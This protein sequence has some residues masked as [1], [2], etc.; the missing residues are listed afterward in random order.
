MV[1]WRIGQL[2]KLIG[3]HPEVVRRYEK[4]GVIPP[5]Q[6]DPHNGW[7]VWPDEEVLRIQ[8]QFQPVKPKQEAG[9][10]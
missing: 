3:R 5:A 10:R 8:E 4:A 9:A 2:A 7:R 6:R 1:M